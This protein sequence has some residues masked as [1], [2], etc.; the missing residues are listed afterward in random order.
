MRKD[1]WKLCTNVTMFAKASKCVVVFT[2]S[3]H[4]RLKNARVLCFE[5]AMFIFLIRARGTCGLLVR[6]L[7]LVNSRRILSPTENN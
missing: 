6:G 5:A 3:P 4:I 2:G 7:G 1:V